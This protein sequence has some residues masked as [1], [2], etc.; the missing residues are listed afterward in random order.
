MVLQRPRA[1]VSQIPKL[2]NTAK[3]P[4]ITSS[5][6]P[7]IAPDLRGPIK[8]KRKR[9]RCFHFMLG[10]LTTS[11]TGALRC[12]DKQLSASTNL[13]T[14]VARLLVRPVTPVLQQQIQST[15]K[16][17]LRREASFAGFGTIAKGLF[18]RLILVVDLYRRGAGPPL[19]IF[20]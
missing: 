12:V 14:L 16:T 2:P 1:R 7:K 17:P 8:A 3:T 19:M 15:I 13:C 4:L 5:K 9:R 20:L 11:T 18:A 10:V 6:K